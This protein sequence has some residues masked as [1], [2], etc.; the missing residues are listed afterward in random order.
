VN[1]LERTGYRLPTEG[2]WEY[3]CRAGTT[4]ARYFGHTP[5]L[6]PQY[7]WCPANSPLG[8][9]QPVG[10]K[11]PNDFGLFDM[12]GNADE[13]CHDRFE[14]YVI[15]RGGAAGDLEPPRSSLQNLAFND[16]RQGSL[17]IGFRVA[18]TIVGED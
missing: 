14:N 18:R 12:Y 10:L 13:I 8:H 6:L 15:T 11:K 1:C 17:A 9:K 4:T 16:P 7:A 2:E 3:A 5:E